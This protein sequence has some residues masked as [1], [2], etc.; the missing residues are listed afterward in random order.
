ML[1]LLTL[2]SLYFFSFFFVYVELD[3]QSCNSKSL[4]KDGLLRLQTLKK[5]KRIN[6]YRVSHLTDDV[7]EELIQ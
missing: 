1:L 4:S 7:L 6:F 5:L 2:K 3:L